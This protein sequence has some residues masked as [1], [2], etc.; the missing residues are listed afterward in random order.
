MAWPFVRKSRDGTH[1]FHT[2]QASGRFTRT[3]YQKS[4]VRRPI[5]ARRCDWCQ[6][7]SEL[8]L[9]LAQRGE[10]SCRI[11]D[12]L[13]QILVCGFDDRGPRHAQKRVG[14]FLAGD[15]RGKRR[16]LSRRRRASLASRSSSAEFPGSTALA[17]PMFARVYSCPQYTSVSS[18]SAAS[19]S[20][21]AYSCWGVPS[22]TRRTRRRTAYRHR[23]PCLNHN[24]R[25]ARACARECRAPRTPRPVVRRRPGLRAD[26]MRKRGDRLAAGSIHRNRVS[27]QNFRDASDMILVVMCG[28]DRDQLKLFSREIIQDRLGL[29]R[30]D[31]R[32]AAGVAQGPDVVVLECAQ[33]DDLKF[34][35]GHIRP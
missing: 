30:V 7:D 35:T 14:G 21:D 34:S 22:N 17:K 19:F 20:S 4:G 3:F 2:G 33:G 11:A 31:Y 12:A 28:K 29:A 26:R 32:R 27:F 5:N 25:C 18:G 15:R 6:L 16:R 1:G 9:P 24:K 13:A 23:T 8:V 10:Y